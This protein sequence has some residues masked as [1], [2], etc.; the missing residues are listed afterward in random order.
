MTLDCRT[1]SA[2][3][4]KGSLTR[5]SPYA[6]V[7]CAMA[8]FNLDEHS[9]SNPMWHVHLQ[10]LAD[11]KFA[12]IEILVIMWSLWLQVTSQD[13]EPYQTTQSGYIRHTTDSIGVFFPPFLGSS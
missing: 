13:P 10:S 9:R 4:V 5:I 11:P 7:L 3:F 1:F 12:P 8:L 6:L 2:A